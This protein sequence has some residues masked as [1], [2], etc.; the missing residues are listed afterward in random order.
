PRTRERRD[1]LIAVRRAIL[2]VAFFAEVVLAI[3][4]LS[5]NSN[6][7]SAVAAPVLRPSI[8]QFGSNRGSRNQAF[9]T[10]GGHIAGIPAPV[11][12]HFEQPRCLTGCGTAAGVFPRRRPCLPSDPRSQTVNGRAA[13]RSATP[14]SGFLRT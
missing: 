5:T 3:S 2:R 8:Q 10:V 14:R 12:A 1:L 13:A 11:N 4:C 7:N 9:P 6:Q